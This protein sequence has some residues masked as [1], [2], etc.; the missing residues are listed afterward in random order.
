MPD[1]NLMEKIVSL[2]K[3]RGFIFQ[4]SEIYGGVEA[5]WDYG[6][7]G[8]LLKNNIKQEWLKRF[9]QFR[10][11]VVLID[12]PVIMHPK[13][14]EASGHLKNF[15]DPLVEC[16]ECHARF[17]AD[18]MEEGEFVGKG[19]AK[20]KNQCTQCGGKEFTG[21]RNF[22]LMFKTFLG[23]VEDESN[24]AY[25]RPE[26][27]QSMF[28]DFALIQE[29]MRLKIPFGVAQIGRSFRNEITTGNFTF[30]SRE[31]EQAEI[32]YF[33]KPGEDEKAYEEWVDEWEE[34]II[35]L[36]IKKE[37]LRRKE[38]KKED[39]SHYSKRTIDIEY[40]FP[41]G[42]SE[43]TG[44]ANR[45]DYDLSQ[46]SKFSGKELSY[47]D[48]E[49]KRKYVPYVIEPSL[50]IDRLLLALLIEAYQEVEGGRTETTDSVKEV[51]LV[52]RFDKKISPIKVAVFPLMKNKPELVK[53]AKELYGMLRPYFVCQYDETGSIGKRYRRQDEIG[54]PYCITIDFET[55]EKGD[56][57]LRDRDTMKQ[58]RIKMEDLAGIL[59]ERLEK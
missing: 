20:A 18:Y 8:S 14:W 2:C 45:T 36:G 44:I 27:A 47:F 46:H 58:E 48:E 34:F 25:L 37:N 52:L 33:V 11:D 31:F 38:H 59:R 29:T 22:N 50:G 49:T 9:V 35:S 56:V 17:R 30:R 24:V 54:T 42:W 13:T 41:F 3:R 10:D 51:E 43:L 28:T 39:L 6:P 1:L 26:T 21:A 15:T 23:P 7:L 55:L 12:T 4:S 19:K 40:K 32:E 57:T 5:L 16:K 53:K